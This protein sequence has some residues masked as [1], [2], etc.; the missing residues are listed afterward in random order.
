MRYVKA[1][2]LICGLV[3]LGWVLAE[4][5]LPAVWERVRQV[6][7]GMA[8][9]LAL[10]ALAFAIDSQTWHMALI[11]VPL[12]R[13]WAYRMWKIRMVG[14]AVNNALPSASLG[15]EVLKALM[16]KKQYG[17]GYRQGVA[18]LILGRTINLLALIVFLAAGF[19][20]MLVSSAIPDVY[21]WTAASGLGVLSVGTG[22]FFV[23]QR[24]RVAS[25]I[26]SWIGRGPWG[27]R[28]AIVLEH[29]GDMDE[30]LVEFY[31]RHQGRFAGAVTLAFV[32]WVLGAV[33]I[34]WAMVFLGAPVSFWEAWIIEATAQLVRAGLFFIPAGIGVQEGA[35]VLICGAI[36]GTPALGVAVSIV[37]R[38]RE[39]VWIAWGFL[40]GTVARTGPSSSE[41]RPIPEGNEG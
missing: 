16:L 32:N 22:L 19:A 21:R 37:R 28:M 29:V 39:V 34:Y 1:L 26:G 17:V 7:W 38:I 24:F 11:A 33:E 3:I 18:S 20:A 9:L 36:T 23:V 14:E 40:I 35:F 4:A 30:R 5:D 8:V 12:N 41:L 27:A 10:Y 13:V 31:S 6:G 2:S 15:G 25:I